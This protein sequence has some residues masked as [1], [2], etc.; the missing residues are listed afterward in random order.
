[1]RK[2]ITVTENSNN[3]NVS[4]GV[5][6]ISDRIEKTDDDHKENCRHSGQGKNNDKLCSSL[7][8]NYSIFASCKT[9][10]R[11]DV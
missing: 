9:L 6:K 4:D 8:I 2:Q 7:V 3:S 1:M 11:D 10:I 5:S